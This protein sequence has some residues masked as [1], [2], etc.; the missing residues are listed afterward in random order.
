MSP[1]LC[2]T[3]FRQA[4]LSGDQQKLRDMTQFPLAVHGAV[5]GVPV[6]K[7]SRDQFDATLTKILDQPMASYE[8]DAL[9]TYTMRDLVDKTKEIAAG[10]DKD[11]NEFRVG[12]LVFEYRGNSCKLVRA[13]LSE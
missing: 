8:G 3:N 13:Y 11:N 12:E 7:I 10:V 6:Q 5:D 4:V 9:I 1:Q 2:W